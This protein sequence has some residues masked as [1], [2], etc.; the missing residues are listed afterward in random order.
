MPRSRSLVTG[1]ACHEPT[2]VTQTLRTSSSGA[3]Q[4]RRVPSGEM[5]GLTR[6]GFPN[7]TWRGTRGTGS[8]AL[9][10]M[11]VQSGPVREE[12]RSRWL[13]EGEGRAATYD[14][15]WAE[16]AAEGENIHGEADFVISLG[17]AVGSVLDAGCGTG[18]VAIELARRGLDVVGVD[19]DPSMLEKATA[20]APELTWVRGDLVDV[21]L[22][23]RFDA[24]L[25]AGNVMIYLA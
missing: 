23:R 24:V 4:A 1:R 5:R 19:L 6:S 12:P 20:K 8:G 9:V 21:D 7:R 16:L 3:I 17:G 13:A 15:R 25:M 11:V 14:N 2:G 22:G 10:V 18:R